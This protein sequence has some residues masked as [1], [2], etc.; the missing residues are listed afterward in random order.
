MTKEELEKEAED[1]AHNMLWWLK[2]PINEKNVKDGGY[3]ILKLLEPRENRIK[4]LEDAL[5]HARKLYGDELEKAYKE[6]DM[7]R[8]G[9]VWQDYDP[10][11]GCYDDTHEGKWVKR[12]EPWRYVKD[13]L[14]KI[15]VGYK[16]AVEV[17][18]LDAYQNSCIKGCDWNGKDFIYQYFDGKKWI[19]DKKVSLLGK[20][21]A[22]R[23][24]V[25]DWPTLPKEV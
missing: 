10:G 25:D 14:P 6:I 18:Y 12:W 2:M 22:W 20:V 15:E 5:K 17:C 13:E 23:Y 21:F 16:V 7:L 9:Y 19:F 3:H 8:Q 11:E 24:E 4:E 1:C